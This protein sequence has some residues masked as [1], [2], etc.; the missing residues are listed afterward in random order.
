ML[1]ADARRRLHHRG[2]GAGGARRRGSR[3]RPYP[4]AIESQAGYAKEFLRQQFRDSFGGDHPPD[5]DVQTTFVPELQDAAERAVSRRPAAV[6]RARAAGGARRDRSG[7]RRRPG[8]GRRPRLPRCRSSTAPGA[9]GASPG[10]RSSRCSTPRRWSTA[11]RR[12]RVLDGPRRRSRR[13]GRTSGRR[14]TPKRTRPTRLTLRAALIESNNRAAT[15]LQQRIGSRPVLRLAVRRR[16]ARSA[17][18]AVAVARHRPGHAARS[19]R[20]VRDVP[21]RRRASRQPRGIMRVIDADGGIAYDNPVADRAR[22]LDGDRSLTRWSRCSR[23]S[24]D[25]GT[26]SAA[27]AA[28]ACASPS[29]ARPARPTSSRT[30]GSSASRRRWSSACGSASISPAT[31]GRE[32]LRARYA[33]PIWSDF[34]RRAARL[35]GAAGVRAAR[36]RLRDEPA[37]PRVVP[38]AGRGLP[39][40]HRVLQGRRRHPD[41]ACARS[42]RAPSSSGSSARSRDSSPAWERGF[43]AASSS[44]LGGMP[45][46][47]RTCPPDRPASKV[48]GP[49]AL[50]TARSVTGG[51]DRATRP[52]WR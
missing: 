40:L 9:A 38:E 19:D 24:I 11:S 15:L 12:C 25:R 44:S 37:L 48:G 45:R 21:E 33:L 50:A 35:R 18:R 31:I 16:P 22:D 14:A 3:V 41:A 32:A 29:A 1:A 10:R 26:A 47:D 43:C 39:G 51:D 36:R 46:R 8:A 7:D 27:R 5:W 49:P 17:G 30:P 6:R 13:R 4:G 52:S 23:T 42:T 2:A 34:M 28:R 20:R